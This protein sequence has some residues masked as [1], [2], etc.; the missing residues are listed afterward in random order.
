MFPAF[1]YIHA[2]TYILTVLET[3]L[4][5]YNY[6]VSLYMFDPNKRR[7]CDSVKAYGGGTQYLLSVYSRTD[8]NCILKPASIV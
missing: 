3:Q 5:D 7:R 4:D 1:I 8:Q 6:A 2:Y